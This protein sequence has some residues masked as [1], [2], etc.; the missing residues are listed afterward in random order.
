MPQ[1]CKPGDIIVDGVDYDPDDTY[2]N[3]SSSTQQSHGSDTLED[4]GSDPAASCEQQP[5]CQRFPELHA[6]LQAA[7]HQL[8]GA[9][10]P[11]L[12]WSSPTDALWISSYNSL[13]CTDA[14]QVSHKRHQQSAA[15]STPHVA[16]QAALLTP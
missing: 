2:S 16:S 5:W 15:P 8:G 7:I 9:V 3:S 12:N 14:D 10:A 13:K 4:D 6:Q 11:K 1:R